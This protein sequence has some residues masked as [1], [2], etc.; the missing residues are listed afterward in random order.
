MSRRFKHPKPESHGENLTY[1]PSREEREYNAKTGIGSHPSRTV[2]FSDGSRVL[3]SPP[4]R[5]GK[6]VMAIPKTRDF[7]TGK[8]VRLMPNTPDFLE[9][10]NLSPEIQ[11]RIEQ[12]E[13]N[14]EEFRKD[15]D[16]WYRA[17]C[18]KDEKH[19]YMRDMGMTNDDI[20]IAEFESRIL[21][22]MA[23][24]HAAYFE[25][26]R[27]E[28]PGWLERVKNENPN[29]SRDFF[30][31]AECV[32][33]VRQHGLHEEAELVRSIFRAQRD[34]KEGEML[35]MAAHDPD[36][37][38]DERLEEA[39]Q[40]VSEKPRSEPSKGKKRK[41]KRM[42][43]YLPEGWTVEPLAVFI[44]YA[45]YSAYLIRDETGRARRSAIFSK[46]RALPKEAMAMAT[47]EN[48]VNGCTDSGF[49]AL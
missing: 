13:R 28:D 38:G 34:V 36:I 6:S 41:G 37:F 15:F 7:L 25:A 16:D 2:T 29:W 30:Y 45:W 17:Q 23:R 22:I 44:K 19:R 33:I 39:A 11:A 12:D 10:L 20:T 21:S 14:W 8:S 47:A 46:I 1:I 5:I 32:R 3:K 48:W 35:L 43:F 26:M 24:D 31:S 27:A 49:P 4:L 9:T 40:T 42:R 18:E